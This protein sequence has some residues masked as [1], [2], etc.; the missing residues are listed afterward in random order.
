[1]E[2]IAFDPP[3]TLDD[4][5]DELYELLELYD[6]ALPGLWERLVPTFEVLELV[7][8]E[9]FERP[10]PD[11]QV[12]RALMVVWQRCDRGFRARLAQ[13]CMERIEWQLRASLRAGRVPSLQGLTRLVRLMAWLDS[14]LDRPL[15][16]ATA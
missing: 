3:D 10:K 11:A 16:C 9:L 4:A 8:F 5:F 14:S 15:F 6:K 13:S 12:L 2:E 7:T 1:M